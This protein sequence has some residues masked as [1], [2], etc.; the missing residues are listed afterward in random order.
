M[1]KPFS[2]P[3]NND[4]DQAFVLEITEAQ[5]RMRAYIG[6]LLAFGSATDDVLQKSNL[7]IWDKREQW[8]PET[9]FLKWAYRICYFQVKAHIR[10]A[11][12]EKLVFTDSLLDTL[13][14]EHPSADAPQSQL[15]ALRH[16]LTKM[17]PDKRS[18]LLE[19]YNGEKVEDLAA[20]HNKKPNAL[21]QT[22]RRLRI[23]LMHCIQTTGT[24][25]PP[26]PSQ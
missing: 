10:D 8:D 3:S 4:L 18:L 6:K 16:C 15:E 7:V 21:S 13:A 24:S 22:L 14:N 26:T 20:R 1:P 19:R 17:D 12:R 23:E 25:Q 11:G 2:S 5:S 9:P